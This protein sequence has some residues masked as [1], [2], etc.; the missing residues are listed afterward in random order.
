LR[1]F[2]SVR[3]RE[4]SLGK[5]EEREKWVNGKGKASFYRIPRRIELLCRIVLEI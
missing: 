4:E 2:W 1:E 3:E 5:R